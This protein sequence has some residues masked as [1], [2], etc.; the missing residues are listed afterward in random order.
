M[1]TVWELIKQMYKKNYDM[2]EDIVDFIAVYDILDECCQGFSRSSIALH[3]D[4]DEEYIKETI[5]DFL[6]FD[7]FEHDIMFN[8]KDL[9]RRYKYNKYLYISNAAKFDVSLTEK[10]CAELYRINQRLGRIEKAMFDYYA[11][12]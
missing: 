6:F 7:G 8:P 11:K 1:K 5:K 10:D 3:L 9:Y 2:T 4:F 12:H